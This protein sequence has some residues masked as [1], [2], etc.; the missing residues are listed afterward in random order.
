MKLEIK[1][2]IA[3]VM[4]LML[5]ACG[6]SHSAVKTEKVWRLKERTLPTG[7]KIKFEYDGS[8]YLI[9]QKTATETMKFHYN[10]KGVLKTRESFDQAGKLVERYKFDS[11][12]EMISRSNID[13]N[14]VLVLNTVFIT[15]EDNDRIVSDKAAKRPYGSDPFT[16]YPSS[17]IIT[18]EKEGSA[19]LSFSR[20]TYEGD[21]KVVRKVFDTSTDTVVKAEVH[22]EYNEQGDLKQWILDTDGDG[23]KQPSITN[24]EYDYVLDGNGNIKERTKIINNFGT[25]V[26]KYE[27]MSMDIPVK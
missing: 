8:G 12:G 18:R 22:K 14:G 21:N 2:S 16:V 9:S 4:S 11:H 26:D 15:T 19:S 6:G 25:H 10:D 5:V 20:Y 24:Y 7:E 1:L 13:V 3:L 23:P 27:W 17:K